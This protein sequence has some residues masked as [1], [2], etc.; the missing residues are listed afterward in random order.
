VQRHPVVVTIDGP[1]GAGKSTVAK[2]LARTLGYRLLDTGAIY[3][4]VALVAVRRGVAWSDAEP[5]ATLARDLE[6]RF[7]F[8]GDANH[9]FLAGEDVSAAIRTPEISQGASQVSAHPPVRTALLDLQRRLGAGGGVV[10]E[11]RD[12]GTVVFPQAQAKFFLVATPAERARRRVAELAERGTIVGYAETLAE[13]SERDARDAG[14][15]VAPMKPAPDAVLIDSSAMT[16]DAVVDA[17]AKA[18]LADSSG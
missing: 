10:V 9:V 12:T 5:L 18:C 3:R 16:I 4:S 11:G 6:I 7:E 14:R 8:V 2:Q 17:M 1:A 15:D 13:M